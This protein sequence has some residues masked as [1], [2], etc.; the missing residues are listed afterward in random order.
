MNLGLGL[1]WFFIPLA[2]AVSLVY[3]ASRHESWP[4]IWK[5]SARLCVTIMVLMVIATLVLLGINTYFV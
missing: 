4:R 2:V 5:R 3:S 1:Y